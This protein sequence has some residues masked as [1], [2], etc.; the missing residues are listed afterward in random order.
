MQRIYVSSTYADLVEHRSTIYRVL[1][2]N[3]YDVVAMEDYVATDERPLEKCLADVRDCDVYVGIY[4]RR[5][6]YVPPGQTESITTLEYREAREAGKPCACFLLADGH[7]LPPEHEDA[8]PG[9]IDEF[10][11]EIQ[12]EHVVGFFK[13]PLE[14]AVEVLSSLRA[15]AVDD[16]RFYLHLAETAF[17]VPEWCSYADVPFSITNASDHDIKIVS[18]GLT[19]LERERYD[20]VRLELPGAP[21]VEY[22]LFADIRDRDEVDLLE[23]L[24]VQFITRPGE[25]EAMRLELTCADG[26]VYHC[27]LTCRVADVRDGSEHDLAPGNFSVT[28]PISTLETLR[29][30]KKGS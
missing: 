13:T 25:S 18:L 6:G 23:G 22:K 27:A 15:L 4:G 26:Y 1:R 20:V 14:L 19:V 12:R 24:N 28:F 8:D 7:V 5:R 17:E 11:A 2:K 16:R 29:E 21:V 10:R 3:R 30:R 9:P